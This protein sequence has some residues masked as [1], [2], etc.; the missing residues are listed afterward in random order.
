MAWFLKFT[1]IYIPWQEKWVFSYLEIFQSNFDERVVACLAVGTERMSYVSF[2]HVR[3]K[4]WSKMF[5]WVVII[6]NLLLKFQLI[7]PC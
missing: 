4:C 6:I 1:R 7:V 2:S 3:Y 5:Q